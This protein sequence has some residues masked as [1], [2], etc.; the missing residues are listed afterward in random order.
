MINL[1]LEINKNDKIEAKDF[2]ISLL[3]TGGIEKF[4]AISKNYY[5][6]SDGI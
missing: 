4:R 1:K 2:I 5:K 3:D 6:E